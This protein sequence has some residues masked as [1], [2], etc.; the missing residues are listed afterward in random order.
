MGQFD[1]VE[2]SPSAPQNGPEAV[3][4][5]VFGTAHDKVDG[6]AERRDDH[7]VQRVAHTQTVAKPTRLND[8]HPFTKSCVWHT[9]SDAGATMSISRWRLHYRSTCVV[10]MSET[11]Y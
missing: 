9:I 10:K 8:T 4:R 3:D 6:E 11:T 1:Y 5:G 2:P 7:R